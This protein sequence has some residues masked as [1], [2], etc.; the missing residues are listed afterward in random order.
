MSTAVWIRFTSCGTLIVR[1]LPDAAGPLGRGRACTG[2]I[3]P[4]AFFTMSVP[5]MPLPGAPWNVQK[6]P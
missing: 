4:S 2:G 3:V 1:G 6:Y 5:Y